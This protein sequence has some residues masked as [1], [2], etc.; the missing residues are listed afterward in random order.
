MLKHTQQLHESNMIL[1]AH[2]PTN[3]YIGKFSP[4]KSPPKRYR[5]KIILLKV[6]MNNVFGRR[7]LS[8][9]PEVMLVTPTST[10]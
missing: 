4:P 8:V 9:S 1:K 6:F 5:Y 3:V 2:T 7:T 10:V